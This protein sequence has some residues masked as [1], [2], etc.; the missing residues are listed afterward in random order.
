MLKPCLGRYI[1]SPQVREDMK[2]YALVTAMGDRLH[3]APIRDDP[4]NILD[5]GTGTGIWCV[6]SVLLPRQLTS[7]CHLTSDKWASSI[8]PLLCRAST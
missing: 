7:V 1:S 3:Y 2:H 5:L 8:L 6:E 4:E